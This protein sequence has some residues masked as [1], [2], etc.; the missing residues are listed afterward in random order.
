[1]ILPP[2]DFDRL[3]SG[4]SADVFMCAVTA[5][6]YL[7]T[8]PLDVLI[9]IPFRCF[10]RVVKNIPPQID[11]A[12]VMG[13]G[14]DI[15]PNMLNSRLDT[16]LQLHRQFPAIKFL[17]SGTDD[18]KY[19]EPLYMENYLRQRGVSPGNIFCDGKGFNTAE[20]FKNLRRMKISRAV[21][22]TSDFHLLRCI[23][24]ARLYG[25]DAYGWRIPLI[26]PASH[27]YRWRYWLREKFA[28][29][30]GFG[31]FLIERFKHAH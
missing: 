15:S 18:E 17:L 5:A 23:D 14:Y 22:V 11:F 3:K 13:C 19:P 20:T 26:N 16:A 8:L 28:H 27:P 9:G 25:V 24:T 31:R 1:M 29:Y 10:S 2:F 4:R 6:V 30:W 7:V 21:I 12:V